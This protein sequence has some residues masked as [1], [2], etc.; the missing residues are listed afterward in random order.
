MK[1]MCG[2]SKQIASRSCQRRV[3]RKRCKCWH[4]STPTHPS[5]V[6]R[7]TSP[8]Q[9]DERSEHHHCQIEGISLQLT[10]LD[11]RTLPDKNPVIFD[12][13]LSDNSRYMGYN[14]ETGIIEICKR[15]MYVIDWTIAVEDALACDFVRFGLTV[16]ETFH[17]S[18]TLPTTSGQL[19]GHALIQVNQ[20]PTT[21]KLINDTGAAVRLS[22]IDPTAHLRIFTCQ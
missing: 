1:M 18:S 17:T 21:V 2:C 7:T 16:N 15:G 20:V 8:R 5:H 22:N 9:C 19:T 12:E 11:E 3:V 14:P 6:K 13:S 10:T 4:A